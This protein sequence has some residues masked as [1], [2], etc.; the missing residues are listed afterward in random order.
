MRINVVHAVFVV[1]VSFI[2]VS[3]ALPISLYYISLLAFPNQAKGDPLYYNGTLVGYKYVYMNISSA[4]FFNSSAT[5][6]MSP[7][8]TESYAMQQAEVLNES[9]HV[10]Y[11]YLVSLVK[12]YTYY[13]PLVGK[14]L[15][16][17]NLLNLALL[18]YYS[19][20]PRFHQLYRLGIER[21]RSL[22]YS[23]YS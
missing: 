23:A 8:V 4:G 15:V 21:I 14:R 3:V 13:D 9:C 18:K 20:N 19:E 16:N 1:L 12:N 22:N 5:Y 10:P 2:I 6:Y 7:I 17:V 11:T